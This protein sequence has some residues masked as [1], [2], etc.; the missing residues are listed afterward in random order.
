MTRVGS[1][2]LLDRCAAECGE[3]ALRA[4]VVLDIAGALNRTGVQIA[5]ELAEDLLIGLADNVGQ[6]VEPAAVWHADADFLK[7]GFSSLLAHPSNKTMAD[8]PPSRENR[9]CPTNLVCKKVSKISASLSLSRIRR[10]SSRGSDSCGRSTRSWIHLRCTGSW[11][12]MYS[13]PVVRQ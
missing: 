2:R 12:C 6:H 5:L 4:Q 8:S 7:A 11:M 3:L 10:C 9:F 1:H 13:M